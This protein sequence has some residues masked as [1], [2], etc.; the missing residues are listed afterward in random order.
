MLRTILAYVGFGR[1]KAIRAAAAAVHDPK[2]ARFI[3]DADFTTAMDILFSL[4]WGMTL[5][6]PVSKAVGGLLVKGSE[7]DEEVDIRKVTGVAISKGRLIGNLPRLLKTIDTTPESLVASSLQE[8]HQVILENVMQHSGCMRNGRFDLWEEGWSG[9]LIARNDATARRIAWL[10]VHG[11]LVQTVLPA[12]I[13]RYGLDPEALDVLTRQWWA[14]LVPADEAAK[15]ECALRRLRAD[16]CQLVLETWSR[17]AP[18]DEIPTCWRLLACPRDSRHL[19]A[20][21]DGLADAAAPVFD[22]SQWLRML[23]A[24]RV[25]P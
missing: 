15:L 19:Q 14:V 21:R 4:R 20:L 18:N 11:G 17:T 16:R 7:R 13:T 3:G 6:H 25:L 9:R 23:A 12:R 22:L 5:S 8:Q 10:H 24:G 1:S 2:S